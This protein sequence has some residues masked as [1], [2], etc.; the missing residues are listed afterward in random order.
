MWTTICPRRIFA[1]P[2]T[3]GFCG[4]WRPNTAS[5]FRRRATASAT[6][7]T[8]SG[9]APRAR[10]CWGPTATRPRPGAPG[11]LAFGAGGL[12]VALAMAGQPFYLVMPEILGVRLDGTVSALGVG[13]GRHP[14][15]AAP[16]DRQ[17]GPGQD[18]GILRAGPAPS[19][20]ARTGRHHQHGGG[21]GGHHLHLSRR[22]P[23]P[24]RFL[25]LQGRERGFPAP[26]GPGAAP[27]R[28]SGGDG[29]GQA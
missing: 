6:R 15:A 25:A 7:C 5:T 28:R 21:A 23:R 4:R 11:M 10:P 13:Q 20:R 17:G 1:T 9:S 18:P 16:P 26:Q 24:S 2:T 27:L 14:G 12:D 19:Q 8:W 29:P 22:T 3:T